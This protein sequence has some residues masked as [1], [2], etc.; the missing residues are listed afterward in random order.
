MHH[1]AHISFVGAPIPV[2]RSPRRV[3]KSTG[4]IPRREDSD[5]VVS[6]FISWV[7]ERAMLDPSVY[8]PS[9]L[10]RRLNACLRR[11]RAPSIEAAQKLLESRPDLLDSAL[12]TLLLGVSEFFRDP[13]VFRCFR[14]KVLPVMFERSAG[15]RIL[16]I[17]VSEGQELYS[18]AMLLAEMNALDRVQLVGMDC[19]PEAI[20]YARVGWFSD[21]EMGGVGE[22]LRNRYFSQGGKGWSIKENIRS[23]IRWNVGNVLNLDGVAQSD[24]IFFRNVAIYLTVRHAD[25]AWSALFGNLSSNGMLVCGKADN[26]PASLHLARVAPCIYEKTRPVPL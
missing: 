18:V 9:C 8:R 6:P 26:P 1:T 20:R 2:R 21:R 16:S 10:N 12:D 7:F 22:E 19:R 11:L 3:V 23:Q 4:A 25:C 13:D 14:E 15:I 5:E 24:I 17:G